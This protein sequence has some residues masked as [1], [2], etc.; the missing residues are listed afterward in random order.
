MR[1]G[2]C[3]GRSDNSPGKAGQRCLGVGNVPGGRGEALAEPE[4]HEPVVLGRLFHSRAGIVDTDPGRDAAVGL[5]DL[6]SNIVGDRL[7][8]GHGLAYFRVCD[9][10][11]GDPPTALKESPPRRTNARRKSVTIQLLLLEI[12]QRSIRD[13][14]EGEVEARDAAPLHGNFDRPLDDVEFTPLADGGLKAIG[15]RG[16]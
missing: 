11:R 16:H 8:L 15:E 5:I 3:T 9:A 7:G 10:S 1:S 6:E 12:Q 4:L 14:L 13:D 2:S